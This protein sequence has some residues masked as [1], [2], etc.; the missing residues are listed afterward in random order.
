MDAQLLAEHWSL[1]CLHVASFS[2]MFS[3]TLTVV[4]PKFLIINFS[5][6]LYHIVY[7]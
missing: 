5:N 2:D 1:H 3:T 4:T 6:N 7:R